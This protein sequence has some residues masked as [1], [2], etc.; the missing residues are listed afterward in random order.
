[1]KFRGEYAAVALL[2]GAAVV[3]AT[4]FMNSENPDEM[5]SAGFRS[6]SEASPENHAAAPYE[7]ADEQPA[8]SRNEALG[9]GSIE[10]VPSPSDPQV[11]PSMES[12]AIDRVRTSVTRKGGGFEYETLPIFSRG[13]AS[14]EFLLNSRP[15]AGDAERQAAI[16]DLLNGRLAPAVDSLRVRV[17]EF[18]EIYSQCVSQLLDSGNYDYRDPEGVATRTMHFRPE[19][20]LYKG[21]SHHNE[22]GS[23][24]FEMR[25]GMFPELD[26]KFAQC[27]NLATSIESQFP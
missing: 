2:A 8:T 1:M 10:V 4:F 22:L 12:Q 15:F 5:E 19:G 3:A 21:A 25:E 26:A 9:A 24:A 27:L 17:E 13:R 7:L 20:R 14:L 11:P 23:V 6:A 18:N 16:H